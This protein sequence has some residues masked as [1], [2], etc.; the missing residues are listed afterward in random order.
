MR[1]SDLISIHP[2]I[3]HMAEY[4]SEDSIRKHGLLST[5]ALLDLFEITGEKRFALEKCRRAKT[6]TIT[7]KEYGSAVIR[8]QQPMNDSMLSKCLNDGL[9]PP[10]WYEIINSMAFFWSTRDRLRT[11]LSAPNYKDK[12]QTILTVDTKR[13]V[14]RYHDNI[15]LCHINSGCTRSIEHRRGLSTFKTIEEFD[16]REFK[17]SGKKNA[18]AEV[19]VKYSVPDI[20]DVIISVDHVRGPESVDKL[21]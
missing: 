12:M 17:K 21:P 11:F 19:S 2:R 3:Y 9:T 8:D 6:E 4:G 15:R 13:L 20:S 16:P 5:T 1:V 18:I 14:E 7:H 10:D